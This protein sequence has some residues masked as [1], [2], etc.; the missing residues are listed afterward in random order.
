M[1]YV[2]KFDIGQ[3]KLDLLRENTISGDIH[4]N[5]NYELPLL[6][7]GDVQ[8]SVN[9]SLVFSY[10]R[11][12]DDIANATNTFNIAPGFKLNLQKRLLLNQTFTIPLAFQG[13]DGKNIDLNAFIN[14]FTFSDDSQRIVR[15][16]QQPNNPS[17][18]PG[19][20]STPDIDDVS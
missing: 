7:F 18:V 4:L 17:L 15:M 11:Y 13:E 10:E 9:L 2:S 19:E 14:K 8:H 5:Y 1:S 12:R 20:P 16:I 3:L 6:S